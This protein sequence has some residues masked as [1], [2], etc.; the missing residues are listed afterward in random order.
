MEFFMT[1]RTRLAVALSAVLLASCG[2]G[3]DGDQSTSFKYDKLVSFGDSLSDVGTHKVGTV[4]ALTASQ[5]GGRWSTSTPAGGDI[6]IERVAG[7]LSV[8]KPCPAETGLLPNI[9]GITGAPVKAQAGCFNYAQGS[10]R[11]TSPLGP[12]SFALQ[13]IPDLSN[14]GA[15]TRTLGLIAKPIRDQM[16]AHL[17]AAGGSYS[18]KELVTVVTGANDVLMELGLLGTPFGAATPQGAVANVALAGAT[19]GALIKTEVLAKGA[20]RVLVL[21]IPDLAGTPFA[22]SLAPDARGL[23]DAMVKAFNAQLTIALKDV[24]GVRLGDVYSVSKD[25][26]ANPGAYGLTN[27]TGLACGPNA[28]GGTAL[29][30][31]GSNLIAGDTSRYQFA[32]DI[33]PTAYGHQLLAQFAIKELA[34]AGWL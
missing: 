14:G 2:G 26:V 13:T 29:V 25:Q 32:D 15:P 10:A 8:N 28:L 23:I 16:A 5:G 30:C 9:P 17:T 33:H 21:N 22:A 6:W 24:P 27:V 1:L 12:N 7:Q 3:G 18:G 34:Q 20:K 4:L 11:I 19:L 31:N